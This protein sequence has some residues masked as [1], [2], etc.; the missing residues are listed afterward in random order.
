MPL[1][2]VELPLTV[3][4]RFVA[5]VRALHAEPNAMKAGEIAALSCMRCGSITPASCD[6]QT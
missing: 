5:D 2:P 6:C 4:R 1:K 3:A